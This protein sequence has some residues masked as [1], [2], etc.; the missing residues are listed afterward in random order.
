VELAERERV[1]PRLLD[2]SCL[3][4]LPMHSLTRRSALVLLCLAGLASCMDAEAPGG[5]GSQEMARATKVAAAGLA[6]P[7]VEAAAVLSPARAEARA[8]IRRASLSLQVEAGAEAAA[9]VTA[10]ARE[11]GG[12]VAE[13]QSTLRTRAERR[14]LTLRVPAEKLDDALARLSELA[15]RVLERR[16]GVEDVSAQVTDV[17]ARLKTLRAT[18]TELQELLAQA[19]ESGR[20]LE[21]VVAVHREL[22]SIRTQVE[23]LQA[24]ERRL[25]EQV[26]L[27]TITVELV[28]EPEAAALATPGWDPL[29]FAR[30][31]V[32][33]LLR[34]LQVVA[35][36]AMIVV[37]VV[38]PVGALIG[39][40]FWLIW[41]R[42]RGMVERGVT[43][44]ASEGAR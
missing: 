12:F 34:A 2:H 21:D 40:P 5:P 29:R 28:L 39:A 11:L 9:K 36:I 23:Q 1:A 7:A 14:V 20:G 30:R 27:A 16:L 41:R 17:A 44:D 15:Q 43:D 24:E 18:E 25:G 10:V 33:F 31:C 6:A 19:R 42:R 13:E 4:A 3:P 38:L 35:E 22:T 26:A 32:Q 8:L 37:V